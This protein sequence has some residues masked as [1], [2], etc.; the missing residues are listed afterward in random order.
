MCDTVSPSCQG[1]APLFHN[2]NF[3]LS[4]GARRVTL[5]FSHY[6]VDDFSCFRGSKETGG[7]HLAGPCLLLSALS[8]RVGCRPR[9]HRGGSQMSPLC[10]LACRARRKNDRRSRRGKPENHAIGPRCRGC[11]HYDPRG[12]ARAGAALRLQRSLPRADCPARRRVEAPA[13]GERFA[14]HG[15]ARAHQPGDASSCTGSS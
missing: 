15:N 10:R 13:K 2:E 12:P 3:N 1:C 4:F 7:H 14:G 6:G 5:R 11:S 9:G 8:G